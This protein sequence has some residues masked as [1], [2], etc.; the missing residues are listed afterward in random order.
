[1]PE[2]A[3]DAALKWAARVSQARQGDV[4]LLAEN[5]VQPGDAA[6]A[7]KKLDENKTGAVS[8]AEFKQ[9]C[10]LNAFTLSA[11]ELKSLW[12]AIDTARTEA[13]TLRRTRDTLLP[14]LVSG[15]LRISDLDG[16]LDRA[17]LAA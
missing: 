8:F 9:F 3:G 12:K 5:G 1:M 6:T 2:G 17:G 16:F 7:F 4:Q 14:E 15:R 11:D 13:E 10:T